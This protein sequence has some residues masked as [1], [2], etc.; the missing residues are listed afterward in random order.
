MKLCNQTYT[1]DDGTQ[2]KC[3]TGTPAQATHKLGNA[4]ACPECYRDMERAYATQ[5]GK[6]GH[7]AIAAMRRSFTRL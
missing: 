7:L 1:G 3:Q 5:Y 4:Y 6:H 2:R